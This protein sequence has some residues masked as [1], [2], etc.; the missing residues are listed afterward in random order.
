MIKPLEVSCDR[1]QSTSLIWLIY[2]LFQTVT[3]LWRKWIWVTSWMVI[4]YGKMIVW[5]LKDELFFLLSLLND[6]VFGTFSFCSKK[7][8]NTTLTVSINVDTLDG[9]DSGWGA[10]L[11]FKKNKIPLLR[12]L[13]NVFILL[14]MIE[15]NCFQFNWKRNI[16]N[17]L[18]QLTKEQ[19]NK[20]GEKDGFTEEFYHYSDIHETI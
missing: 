16:S 13:R 20:N 10:S 7:S 11:L 4:K 15:H 8:L 5:V 9:V 17:S 1:V 12:S 2:V 6:E 14:L 19:E 3:R 18:I